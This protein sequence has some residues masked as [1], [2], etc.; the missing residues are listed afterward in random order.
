MTKLATGPGDDGLVLKG[1]FVLPA[2]ATFAQLDPATN[3]VGIRLSG[4][5]AP[6][7]DV[8]LPGGT[9]D[10]VLKK[11]WKIGKT[12]RTYQNKTASPPGGVI[13]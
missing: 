2:G 10:S 13:V 5:T 11:G 6:A 4:A 3:G 1:T 8:T 7:L 12:K 9:Y